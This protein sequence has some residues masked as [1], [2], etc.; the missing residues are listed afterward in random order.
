MKS[1]KLAVPPV[2]ARIGGRRDI[3]LAFLPAALEIVETPP[4]PTGRAIGATLILLFGAAIAWAWWGTIDVVASAPGRIVPSGRSKIVQPLEAGVVR[5]IR[6]QDGQAV[7]AGEVL[8]ELDPTVNVAERDRLQNDFASEQLNIARLQAALAKD[9]DPVA[10]FRP[11][12]HADPALVAAQRQLLASQVA[13]FRAK[14]AALDGQAAQKEAEQAT[15]GASIHK[16]EA[17]I[18]TI[19][20]RVEIRASLMQQGLV[21]RLTYFETLQQLVEESEEL[22]VQRSRLREAAAA[23]VST[24]ETRDQTVAEYHHGLS[25]ELTRSEQKVSGLAQD[26]IKAEQRAKLQVLTA[27]VDG[28]VQQLAVHTIGGVVTPAQSLLVVVPDDGRLEIEAMVSN[29]DIGFVHP[30]Q[31][32]EI[33]VD[34]FDFT[35]YGLLHGTVLSLS[36]DAIIREPRTDSAP[37]AASMARTEGGDTRNQEL[38]YGARVSLERGQ[39]PAGDRWTNLSAGMAVTAEIRTGSRTI[40]SYLL[41]PLARYHQEMLRER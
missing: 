24:R 33:K 12:A 10:D 9:G 30:G 26:L 13:E 15:I 28:V 7:R 23:I 8:I 1:V 39:M 5:G 22:S 36:S 11:P 17:M 41:S 35:R 19:S 40:L 37:D 31:D 16:L 6:V 29:R 3:E 21:S 25:D 27:P 20:P 34:A 32:V 4:S 18:P 2:P 14:I 38:V